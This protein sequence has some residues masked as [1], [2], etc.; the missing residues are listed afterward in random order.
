M[1]PLERTLTTNWR[2]FTPNFT[3]LRSR[4]QFDRLSL[5]VVIRQESPLAT[6]IVLTRRLA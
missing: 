5:L 6:S 4:Q 1:I 3:Q 2:I